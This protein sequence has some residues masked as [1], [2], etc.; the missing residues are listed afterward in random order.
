MSPLP[1][2]AQKPPNIWALASVT[3]GAVIAV[4]L[5]SVL[6]YYYVSSK[7]TESGPSDAR[8]VTVGSVWIP[9][10]P[11]AML[12]GTASAQ[13][14]GVTESTLN[15]ESKDS[16]ERVLSFYESALKK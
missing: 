9:I 15:F 3:Y 2:R 6:A 5:L 16:A 10:Y 12:E 4:T 13:K 14:D 7:H 11:S 8:A 1:A